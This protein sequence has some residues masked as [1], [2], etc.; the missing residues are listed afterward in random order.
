[1]HGRGALAWRLPRRARQVAPWSAERPCL[2][3]CETPRCLASAIPSRC[4]ARSTARSHAAHAPLTDRSPW[5]IG[6]SSPVTVRCSVGRQAGT[7]ES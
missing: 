7:D 5:T 3:P 4:R 2:R 1:M 6:E